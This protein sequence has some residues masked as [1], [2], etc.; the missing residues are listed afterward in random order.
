MPRKV[1]FLIFFLI[2][3]NE[4]VLGKNANDTK[5]LKKINKNIRKIGGKVKE[6]SKR[7]P[8]DIEKLFTTHIRHELGN[9]NQNGFEKYLSEDND[10]ANFAQEQPFWG[11]RGRRESSESDEYVRSNDVGYKDNS[12]KTCSKYIQDMQSSEKYLTAPFWSNRGRRDSDEISE[13]NPFWGNRGRRQEEP[14]FW[15][16]RGRRSKV[17]LK[18]Q[19]VVVDP[20]FW[21]SRGRR[22]ETEPFWGNRGR[23]DEDEP[24]WGNRGRRDEKEP[25]WGNRGRRQ[26]NEPFWGTRGRR[27]TETSW[28]NHGN[29]QEYGYWK[30]ENSNPFWGN[31]GRKKYALKE[32]IISAMNNI[33][34]NIENLA[35]MRRGEQ[36]SFW[37]QRGR[38]SQL[39]NFFID[40]TRNTASNQLKSGNKAITTKTNF[41]PTAHNTMSDDRIFAEEPHY[42]LIE[43]N[44]RSSA[45]DDPFFISRGKKYTNFKLP[46]GFRDRRGAIEDLV[47]SVRNDPYYIARGKKDSEYIKIGNSTILKDEFVKAKELICSAIDLLVIKNDS[48]KVKR[49]DDESERERRTT[50]KKLAAQLQIDPYFVSRGKKSDDIGVDEER[51]EEFVNQIAD[52]CN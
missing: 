32:N 1:L 16:N 4:I 9:R 50:L 11:N 7:S 46:K 29:K 20:P 17:K 12:C 8:G 40:P 13:Y 37:N 36:D 6:R 47:K 34:Y 15:G 39:E 48:H 27:E 44:T 19:D 52:M 30:A 5:I 38:I 49:D 14:P 21:S 2:L 31:R 26:E 18:S 24:F 43:R 3:S 23:R 33:E 51:L 22:D 42:I 35:R 25:F 28:G 45:E 10:D 41:R